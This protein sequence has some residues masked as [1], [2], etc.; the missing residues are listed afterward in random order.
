MY[1]S[2]II[3]SIKQLPEWFKIENYKKAE[4]FNAIEW[5]D[6]F[7]SRFALR[8]GIV[9]YPNDSMTTSCRWDLIKRDGLLFYSAQRENICHRVF[10][11]TPETVMLRTK[12]FDEKD[13]FLASVTSLTNINV[14][15]GFLELEE[16]EQS[17]IRRRVHNVYTYAV[18]EGQE[19]SKKDN[20]DIASHKVAKFLSFMK[21][22]EWAYAPYDNF[23]D[24]VKTGLKNKI[25]YTRVI[26]NAT[27]EQI[28]K[29]FAIWLEEERKRRD[30]YAPKKNFSEYIINSWYE[31]SV[32]PYLDL[33]FWAKTED[34]KI[35]QH[36][37]AQ[38]IFPDAYSVGSNGDPI[39]K[40][41][42]TKKTAKALM[43][44]TSM[45]LLWAQSYE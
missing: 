39:G 12:D 21:D 19:P 38:A 10:F 31:S 32:L 14:F 2:T 15:A 20:I 45:Y 18:Q 1:E 26:L 11:M 9:R 36:V 34:V 44:F 16:K 27:D 33:S 35:N 8:Q 29:D 40:L 25:A 28:K 13:S 17:Q 41:K 43:N 7:I 3:K 30:S 22:A 37:L 4:F 42:T 23:G 6:E 5:H 24:D